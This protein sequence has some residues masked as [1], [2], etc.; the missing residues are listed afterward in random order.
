MITANGRAAIMDAVCNPPNP[1]LYKRTAAI[2][3]CRIPQISF[4]D[5]AGFKLPF[6][7]SMPK[8]KVAES[9]EVI[10]NVMI[11]K[12]AKILKNQR[13]ENALG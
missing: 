13:S 1:P 12:V 2:E 8:T 7:V 6:D 9:A 5:T 4:V 10:K 11:N 3:D